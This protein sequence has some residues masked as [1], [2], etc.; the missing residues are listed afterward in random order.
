V[1]GSTRAAL[2]ALTNVSGVLPLH[3]A[4]AEHR[5]RLTGSTDAGEAVGHASRLT[6]VKPAVFD[7]HFPTHA[8]LPGGHGTVPVAR[9]TLSQI[10][11]R[12]RPSGRRFS[13]HPSSRP[14]TVLCS[15]I[16]SAFRFVLLHALAPPAAPFSPV[17]LEPSAPL[18]VPAS[19][20]CPRLWHPSPSP[21]QS[22]PRR[23][24]DAPH[25]HRQRQRRSPC[26]Q[27]WRK[28]FPPCKIHASYSHPSPG[29][30]NRLPRS[31]H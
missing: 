11:S 3:R 24:P 29:V 13:G 23:K 17:I 28:A 15:Q 8:Q 7:P 2:Q 14:W 5:R 1:V 18:S 10:C 19:S 22:R 30:R 6:S 21:P 4:R 12:R 9:Q 26:F 25:T 20:L 27:Q 31:R 16:R